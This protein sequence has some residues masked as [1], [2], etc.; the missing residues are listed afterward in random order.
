MVF[1]A[2]LSSGGKLLLA[3][4]PPAER[5]SLYSD[6]KWA[7]RLDQRPALPALRRELATVRE[8]GF[9]LN[10]GAPRRA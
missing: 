3:A 7:D 9:S 6:E 5:E 10:K 2:H 1:P 4:L 8:R